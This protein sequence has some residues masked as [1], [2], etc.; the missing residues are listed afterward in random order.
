MTIDRCKGCNDLKPEEMEK[1]RFIEDIFRWSCH[2]WGYKEVRTPTLEYLNLFTS[3][4][5]LTPEMLGKVYSFLDWDG[6]SGE[7]VVLRPDGTIP[8]ARLYIDSLADKG[9]ARLFYVTNVFA[10]EPTGSKSRERWQCGAELMGTNSSI[11]DVELIALSLEVLEKL[12]LKDI[13][14]KISHA[15][16]IRAILKKVGLTPEEEIKLFDEILDGKGISLDNLKLNKRELERLLPLFELKGRS[17][18]FL[19]NVRALLNGDSSEIASALDGFIAVCDALTS[20]GINYE[21]D[22]ASGRGFEYYTGIMFQLFSGDEKVGGGGRYDALI[23]LMGGKDT[24]ASG[25]ALYLDKLM[26][27]LSS[28]CKTEPEKPYLLIK[29]HTD[30]LKRAF[31]AA[32]SLRGAGY[33]VEFFTTGAKPDPV[34]WLLHIKD[35]GSFVLTDRADNKRHQAKSLE[36]VLNFLKEPG[37]GL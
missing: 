13:E 1:F 12:G 25:F 15:G 17:V 32:T 35:D 36:K 29:T 8:V 6:W 14:L 34:R 21:I 28:M 3:T 11:A 9:T 27:L 22:L 5:T 30:N 24:P 37:E 4:G 23:P 33:K 10:F 26:G 2:K 20:L 19:K 18:G 7:R 31:E 16:V